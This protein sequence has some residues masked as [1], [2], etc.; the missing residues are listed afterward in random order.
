[1]KKRNRLPAYD[2]RLLK[3]YL[4]PF[5]ENIRTQTEFNICCVNFDSLQNGKK[6]RKKKGTLDTKSGIYCQKLGK[7][8]RGKRL[9]AFSKGF[10]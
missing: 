1:M 4:L 2:V 5:I 9:R 10:H 8:H 3:V 7:Q 6:I